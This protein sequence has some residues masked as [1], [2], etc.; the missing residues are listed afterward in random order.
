MPVREANPAFGVSWTGRD[1]VAVKSYDVQ[2]STDGGA[3]WK[4][5]TLRE[6]HGKYAF[7]A[8]RFDT[9]KLRP[10]AATVMARATSNAGETQETKLKPN[11]AGYQNNVPQKIAITLA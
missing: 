5:A 8:W 2:V 7:R 11:P 3:S 6:D 10:G 1:D 9:G 4:T